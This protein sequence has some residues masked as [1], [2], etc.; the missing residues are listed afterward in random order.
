MCYHSLQQLKSRT[1]WKL[2]LNY[3]YTKPG[4]HNNNVKLNHIKIGYFTFHN[5]S[6]RMVLESRILNNIQV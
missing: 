2:I 1:T 6:Q 4:T 3:T 5:P